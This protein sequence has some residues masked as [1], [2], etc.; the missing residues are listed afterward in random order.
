MNQPKMACRNVWKLYGPD[1]DKFLAAHD[2]EPDLDTIKE[3]G[4]TPQFGTPRWRS[5]R[6]SS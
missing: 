1:P 6:A 5:M 4:Y 3:N 2:G